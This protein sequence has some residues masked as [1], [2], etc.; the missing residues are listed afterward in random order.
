MVFSWFRIFSAHESQLA[1]HHSSY[2]TIKAHK[3]SWWTDDGARN[4][5]SKTE[6]FIRLICNLEEVPSVLSPGAPPNKMWWFG[7]L[8]AWSLAEII[9]NLHFFC[10]PALMVR[11]T[12]L[13]SKVLKTTRWWDITCVPASVYLIFIVVLCPTKFSTVLPHFFIASNL[14]WKLIASRNY[15]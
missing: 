10:I 6:S 2:T 14:Q 11:S 13:G 5:S 9:T 3:S 8:S 12:S 1:L 4:T 15:Q 7:R